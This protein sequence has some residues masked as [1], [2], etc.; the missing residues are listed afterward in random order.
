MREPRKIR[1]FVPALY[2][3]A[4]CVLCLALLWYRGAFLAPGQ[5]KSGQWGTLELTLSPAGRFIAAVPGQQ[6]AAF[7]SEPGWRVQDFLVGDLDQDAEAELLLLV[8]RRGHYGPSHPFWVSRND[9]AYSQHIF[10]YKQEQGTVQPVWMSSSLNPRV[11]SW[12]MTGE[13]NL[14]ILTPAGEDTLWGW[15]SWGIERLDAPLLPLV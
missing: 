9:Y 8:W 3:L 14:Q 4:V 11:R 2:W 15:G 13:G 12:S 7:A 6:G 10:I 5:A 1:R